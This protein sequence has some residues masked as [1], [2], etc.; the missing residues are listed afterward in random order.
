MAPQEN[1]LIPSF[2][3]SSSSSS[4]NLIDLN[5]LTRMNRG[6]TSSSSSSKRLVIAA[7]KEKMEMYSSA[8][9]A[10]CTVGGI[11]SCGPTHTAVTP[12][13]LV[14]CNMQVY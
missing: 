5:L 9:Y 14:K 6:T 4:K 10:S 8:F 11:F 1:S 12:L 3:Y 7:P 2:I 13:D